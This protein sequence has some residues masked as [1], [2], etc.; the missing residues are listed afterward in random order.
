MKCACPECKNDIDMSKYPKAAV[1][2]VIECNTCGILLEIT[3]IENGNVE[4][5]IVD[6]G[7]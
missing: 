6:E 1:S 2:H 5:E 4:T 3:K 7:K